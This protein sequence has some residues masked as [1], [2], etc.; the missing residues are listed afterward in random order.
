MLTEIERRWPGR[1]TRIL[2][3]THAATAI[4]LTR[5]L[6][7]QREL[8]LRVGCCTVSEFV[9]KEGRQGGK[10]GE[11]EAKRLGDGSFLKDGALRDWGFEDIE[12]EGGKVCR[13][14]IRPPQMCQA[15]NGGV[16]HTTCWNTRLRE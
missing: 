7:G 11:W 9:P 2:F 13:H 8:P 1:H 14:I 12:L 4:A 3:I 15:D 6:I 5:E 16:G 10:L